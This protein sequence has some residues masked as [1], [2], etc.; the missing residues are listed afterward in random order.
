ML[1][2]TGYIGVKGENMYNRSPQKRYGECPP[3]CDYVSGRNLFDLM[4]VG[5]AINANATP[6]NAER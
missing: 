4:A 3:Q 2:F 1:L 6:R 5:R